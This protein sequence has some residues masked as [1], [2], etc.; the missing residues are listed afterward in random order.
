MAKKHSKRTQAT[1]EQREKEIC[2]NHSSFCLFIYILGFQAW[3]FGFV[4]KK[5][6]A[7]ERKAREPLKGTKIQ[8]YLFLVI[9]CLVHARLSGPFDHDW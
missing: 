3:L 6:K 5:K 7:R 9:C 1:K 2:S 4:K 8:N